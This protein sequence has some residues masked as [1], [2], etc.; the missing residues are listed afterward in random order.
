MNTTTQAKDG[1]KHNLGSRA[2][3]GF[4]HQCGICPFAARRPDSTFERVMRWH[5]TW[6]PAWK[7]HTR[8]YG[9]KRLV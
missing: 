3:A 5:R 4:C 6:C 9:L 7:A 1:R 2:L 8:V